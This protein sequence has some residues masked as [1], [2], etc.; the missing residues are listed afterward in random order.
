MEIT[1][2]EAIQKQVLSLNLNLNVLT[3]RLLQKK[4][5]A[6]AVQCG[7]TQFPGMAALISR[8][9]HEKMIDQKGAGSCCGIRRRQKKQR[10]YHGLQ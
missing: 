3:R 9:M 6:A 2:I 8:N 1:E 7:K 4:L 10:R 5:S